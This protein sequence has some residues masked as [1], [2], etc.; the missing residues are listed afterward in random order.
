[1]PA[2]G[3]NL[4]LAGL[5]TISYR[6]TVDRVVAQHHGPGASIAQQLTSA[7]SIEQP[8]ER[9]PIQEEPFEEDDVI[10]A[11]TEAEMREMA[12]WAREE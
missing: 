10:E 11:L 9:D 4:G 7:R 8:Q 12:N 5:K 1:M 2:M 6:I 3:I